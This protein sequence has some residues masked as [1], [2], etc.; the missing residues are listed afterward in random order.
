MTKLTESAVQRIAES[1]IDDD[2]R[3]LSLNVHAIASSI[4]ALRDAFWP[5]GVA[6][7]PA[8][9]IAVGSI[10][11]A[12]A[13]ISQSNVK[14]AEAIE[15]HAEAINGLSKTLEYIASKY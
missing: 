14:I 12:I 6:S 8:T 1:L 10:G 9:G 4:F 11:E 3:N 5:G 13:T 15:S 7:D 2:E